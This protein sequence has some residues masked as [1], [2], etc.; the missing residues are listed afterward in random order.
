MS[1]TPLAGIR[2]DLRYAWRG[3]AQLVLDQT[4]SAGQHALTGFWFRQARFLRTLRF[5]VLG[6][7][8]HLC[9]SAAVAPNELEFTYIH[10][11][12][13][14]GG[15][16]G[17]GS[18]GAGEVDGI[19]HR[20]LDLL[21]RL[22]VHAASFDID[23]RITNRWQE[24]LVL[25]VSWRL[26]ADYADIDEAHFGN[27]QQTAP[28]ETIPAG[29]G[30]RIRYLHPE[31]PFETHVHGEGAAWHF[32]NNAL[33]AVLPLARQQTL[34][35]HLQVRAIDHADP[36]DAASEAEREGRLQLWYD[37][38]PVLRAPGE[39]PAVA[40]AAR[41][42]HD[43]GSFAMLEGPSDEWLMPA[44]G[45][46]LYLTLWGRD[47]LTSGWQ[48]GLFDGG[49]ILN[50]VVTALARSQGSE[51]D[52]HRDEEPGRIIN[53]AKKDPLARVGITPFDRYYADY[54]S[55][56]MY[57]IGL[58]FSYVLTGDLQRVRR[59]WENALRV[60]AWART[61]GD[62]DGDGYLEYLTRSEHGP[63]HQGWKDSENAVV[64]E[65]GEMV[66]PPIAPCEIQGYHYAAL[67]YMAAF[68]AL[69]RKWR[70]ARMFWR[71]ARTLKQRFNRDFWLDDE[72]YPAFGLDA[73]KRPIR[74]ITSNGAHCLPTGIISD[75]HIE[76]LV[77][78]LFAPDLFSGWGI[79]T[80]SATNPAYNP[81]DYHLGSIWPVENASILFGLRRYGLNERA[82]QL[83]T[84]LFDLAHLWPGGR[85]PEC[86]GGY[87]RLEA[88]HPGAYP[89]ANVPQAWN[90][91]A[92][93]LVLQCLLGLIP[94]APLHLLL[95]DP[96]LPAWLPDVTI[97]KL[98]IGEAR[99][100]L[101]FQ[102]RADGR[103][104]FTVLEKHGSV[105][106]LHQPWLESFATGLRE[107]T[108]ALRR[109][110]LTT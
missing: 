87:S 45:V 95:V 62:R 103:S 78:R 51:D 12:V 15:G 107:R 97:E 6:R 47:A 34:Q 18:G 31:L 79:R 59:H 57:I 49:D 52:P 94:V 42:L 70:L 17:S 1:F 2:P 85:I 4:G 27:R 58:G 41:A 104:D 20:D 61:H 108:A 56:F 33:T 69:Q 100:S 24:H 91:S 16:G 54:A 80:L 37:R 90:Q 88:A 83:A 38:L 72:G 86:V 75:E 25:P 19:L 9:S 40:I 76:P 92:L 53:Q 39:A 68:A 8:P 67:Q 82:E 81:L 71:D 14:A 63:T 66:K 93:P 36:I 22:R 84:A 5:E 98:R 65:R 55:P 110:L 46:P 48:A 99:V 73:E 102:R 13:T 101:R 3:P 32:H 74:A 43:L 28:I 10:P 109:S 7:I 23:L 44:A 21:L 26:D 11:E 35:L 89:R 77:R 96:I 105:R 64:N 60:L 106:V 30:V 29:A 50:D